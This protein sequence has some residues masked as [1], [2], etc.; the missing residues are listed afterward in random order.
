MGLFCALFLLHL[1]CKS[2]YLL[3]ATNYCRFSKIVCSPFI[4]ILWLHNDHFP[5]TSVSWSF[6][7]SYNHR[8]LFPILKCCFFIVSRFLLT[9]QNIQSHCSALPRLQFVSH[10]SIRHLSIYRQFLSPGKVL[11]HQSTDH[12][13]KITLNNQ[14]DALVYLWMIHFTDVSTQDSFW[15]HYVRNVHRRLLSVLYAHYSQ[16]R[17]VHVNFEKRKIWSILFYFR[18][19]VLLHRLEHSRSDQIKCIVSRLQPAWRSRRT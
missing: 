3:C 7:P 9:K 14:L 11:L 8:Y 4:L 19:S 13:I 17:N 6:F 12:R 1:H 18:R 2:L 16:R 5:H 10:S 15:Y